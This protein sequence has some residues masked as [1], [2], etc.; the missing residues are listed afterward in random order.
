LP[1]VVPHCGHRLVERALIED[2]ASSRDQYLLYL[3]RDVGLPTL[4]VVRFVCRVVSIEGGS[5]SPSFVAPI[6]EVP[7]VGAL[8]QNVVGTLGEAGGIEECP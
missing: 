7:T 2:V 4:G 8:G 3:Q 1:A 5:K 6:A